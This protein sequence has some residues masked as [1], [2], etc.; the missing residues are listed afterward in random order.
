[1]LPRACAT[2]YVHCNGVLQSPYNLTLLL[3]KCALC[4]QPMAATAHEAPRSQNATASSSDLEAARVATEAAHVA[5]E[6]RALEA[7]HAAREAAPVAPEA[8]H[9]ATA[10][11]PTA[12]QAVRT[13]DR[14][15]THALRVWVGIWPFSL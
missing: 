6:A 11:A 15:L 12:P 10:A 8:A 1:M 4:V 7:A 5:S 3:I 2:T 14:M 9:V 13:R